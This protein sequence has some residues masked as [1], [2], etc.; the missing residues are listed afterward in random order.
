MILLRNNYTLAF[1]G[2]YKKQQQKKA[3]EQDKRKRNK[4]QIRVFG[5]VVVVGVVLVKPTFFRKEQQCR[6]SREVNLLRKGL[7]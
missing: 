5:L 4:T 1:G 7:T 2:G 6:F 3:T